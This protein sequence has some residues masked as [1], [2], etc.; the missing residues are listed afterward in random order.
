MTP[1][2]T[3]DRNQGMALVKLARKTLAE[4]LHI[5]WGVAETNA[6]LD[7]PFF[8]H[9][10]ATF[11]T[12]KRQG[13][14]RGCIGTIMPVGTIRESIT[15]N[16]LSAAFKDPRFNPVEQGEFD[17]ILIEV[18][19][20]TQPEPLV[21]D[22]PATLLTSLRTGLDGVIIKKGGSSATF[23]PQVWQQIPNPEDFLC[24]LCL[25]AGLSKTAWKEPGLDVYTYQAQHFEEI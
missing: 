12:L 5:P 19:I 22:S 23:L 1:D 3:L 4:A 2:N 7:D 14:L 18:S 17:E 10:Q 25:K 20:L 16:T 13:H 6:D 8:D 24:Q 15:E 9:Q 11:V 21:F